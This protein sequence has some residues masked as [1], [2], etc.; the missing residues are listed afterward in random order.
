MSN[1]TI[2]AT[3]VDVAFDARWAAWLARGRAHERR[4]R[5]RLMICGAL[6]AVGGA[7]VYGFI[8]R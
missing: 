6:L 5:V 3:G 8:G 4:V 2:L 7:V 1:P